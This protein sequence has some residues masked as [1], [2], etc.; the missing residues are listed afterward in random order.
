[1]LC[2]SDSIPG[3]FGP[4]RISVD[5]IRSTFVGDWRIESIE[6]AI[7]HV[8]FNPSGISAWLTVTTR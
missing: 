3:G 8:T 1:M 2:F 7:M 4:R 6:A 5:E